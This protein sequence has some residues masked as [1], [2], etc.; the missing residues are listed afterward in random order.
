VAQLL[1]PP[2]VFLVLYRVPFDAPPA[3]RRERRGVHLTNLALAAAY[4]GLSVLL[5]FWPVVSVLLAVMVPAGVAGV[6]LFSVQHR[7]E[8]VRWARHAEWDA[9][10]ASLRGSSFLRLPP[11]LRWF[12][13]R[14]G[15]HHVHHLAPR[16]PN[17]RLEDCHGA[18]PGLRLGDGRHPA[19][20]PGRPAPRAVGRGRRAH[21]DLRGG[22]GGI[23]ASPRRSGSR[24]LRV[25]TV[26]AVHER[27]YQ[28]ERFDAVEMRGFT[29]LGWSR[30]SAR[31]SLG[32]RRG[33]RCHSRRRPAPA[34][35][36]SGPRR[37]AWC[38]RSW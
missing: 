1:L 11:V 37:S 6:W 25:M 32:L 15:F 28:G 22:R 16:V 23:A 4:G 33:A 26:A 38:W 10:A 21:G 7:F 31:A 14:L 13:G 24:A 5:G 12:T 29:W 9:V 8:G 36:R 18:H 2:L 20:C 3:W 34:G 35:R 19:G 30:R 27:L 17:Y